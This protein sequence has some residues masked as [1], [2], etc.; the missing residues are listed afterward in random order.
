M[1]LVFRFLSE[2]KLQIAF[3]Y[4][5]MYTFNMYKSILI[6]KI[7]FYNNLALIN[8][9][10]LI[11]ACRSIINQYK[12][13]IYMQKSSSEKEIRETRVNITIIKNI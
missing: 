4:V 7:L 11:N 9:K 8:F 10:Q 13:L 3:V 12:T 1:S 5:S 2:L 6:K